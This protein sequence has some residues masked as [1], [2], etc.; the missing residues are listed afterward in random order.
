MSH[1]TLRAAVRG[2]FA[3]DLSKE[4]LVFVWHAGEPLAV[5]IPW[6]RE[7]F[8]IIREEAPEGLKII[9]TFQ[10]NGMLIDEKWCEFIKEWNLSIGLSIDGPARIH[11]AHRKTR[12]GEGTHGRA[13]QG[14]RLL[15]SHGIEFY[16]IAVVTLDS[17]G[18]A[19]EIFD[20]FVEN[21]I[22]HFGL[23]IEE[24]EGVNTG[25][26]LESDQGDGIEDFFRT[27]FRRQQES[28]GSVTIRE[29]DFARQRI[30]SRNRAA[31]EEFVYENEQV[32]P[33]GI[34]S[35]DWQGN[36]STFSPE[37]LGVLTK[38]YG[39]FSF[40]SFLKGGIESAVAGEKFL[41][42]FGDIKAGV[43]KCRA[44]CSYFNLCGGG[45]PANKYFENGSFDSTETAYC[46]N[47]IQLPISI[48]LEDLEKGLMTDASAGR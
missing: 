29:F 48:A 28:G 17:L 4:S 31:S 46:R 47:V 20:F 8:E 22:M 10:S 44:E 13:M 33:F 25:S 6:Y 32:R 11:D 43:E 7:A 37:M 40:G 12:K 24:K 42:A 21:G 3:T 41:S 36:F 1:E 27:M 30:M 26:S 23:N 9:H 34:L 38:E 14:L 5:P 18:Y 16:V 45:A 15:R 35:V 39:S 2:I 19:D